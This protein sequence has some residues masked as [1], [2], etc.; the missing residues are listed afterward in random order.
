[1]LIVVVSCVTAQEVYLVGQPIRLIVTVENPSELT[2]EYT[3]ALLVNGEQVNSTALMVGPGA[4]S[5][6]EISWTPAEP[7]NYELRVEV[8]QDGT[9]AKFRPTSWRSWPRRSQTSPC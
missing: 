8:R 3:V 2:L 6:V 4:S 1:M 5:Q 7:G 9:L